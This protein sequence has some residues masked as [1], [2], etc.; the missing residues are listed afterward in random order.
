MFIDQNLCKKCLDCL[1]ICPMGAIALQN[2]TVRIDD[3]QCVEC[4][5]CQRIEICSEG[6]IQQADEIPYPRILRAVFSDPTTRHESTGVAGR[7]TEEMKTNDVTGLFTRDNIGFSIEL[8]RP[9]IGASLKDL[10]KVCRKVTQMGVQFARENPVMPL[11]ENR[12]TGALKQ[13]ILG[14]KVLSAIVEFTVPQDTA[15]DIIDEMSHFLNA[16]LDTVATMSVI[17]R[18]D[19][20]GDSEFLSTLKNRRKHPY[21]NGKVNLG[22]ADTKPV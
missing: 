10:D 16:E 11:I 2:K 22:L 6:A 15:M 7:G 13:D 12:E 5:V 19:D 1:T 14:E 4:G 8:G 18:A 9:G 21:P 17:A 20:Q 3:E